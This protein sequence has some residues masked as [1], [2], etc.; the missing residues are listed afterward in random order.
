MYNK[1]YIDIITLSLVLI[2]FLLINIYY[3]QIQGNIKKILNENSIESSLELVKEDNNEQ[4]NNTMIEEIIE[5]EAVVVVEEVP[6]PIVETAP[7]LAEETYLEDWYIMIPT[8]DLVAQIQQG[9]DEETLNKSVGHFEKSPVLNGNVC[10]AAH[11][12]GYEINFFEKIKT[13]LLNDIIIYQYGETQ[14]SYAV[15][16]VTIIKET[17]WSYINTTSKENKL[18]L[19]TCVENE[20]EYRLCVQATEIK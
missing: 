3:F 4:N 2:I 5:E 14:K 6:Y 11:N 19:I 9:T 17:D 12:R 13:L 16:N 7:V 18:T 8:I 15:S 1:K 10:L 20:P